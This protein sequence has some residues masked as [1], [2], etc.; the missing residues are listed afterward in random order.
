MPSCRS[1]C[2]SVRRSVGLSTTS[3]KKCLEVIRCS[4]KVKG[5]YCSNSL[6][7][8]Q[9]SF[10]FQLSQ[11]L[12]MSCVLVSISVVQQFSVLVVWLFCK[13]HQDLDSIMEK[14]T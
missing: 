9:C 8:K 10:Y 3:F 7:H 13:E 14:L 2:R 11:Q 1:V 5:V 12:Y 4:E 6:A